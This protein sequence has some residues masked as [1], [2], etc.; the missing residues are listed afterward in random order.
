[1]NRK[2]P[3]MVKR[4][5]LMHDAKLTDLELRLDQP[6]WL[7]HQGEC[8]P[9]IV[10]TQIRLAHPTDPKNGYPLLIQRAPSPH[11]ICRICTR[12]AAELSIV[13]DVRIGEHIALVCRACFKALGEPVKG[14]DD[15]VVVVPLVREGI[16]Q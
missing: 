6:Y 1:M 13:G 10:I 12:F 16:L 5:G 9:L 15:P 8:D 7:L 14:R 2:G 4:G 3:G 11:P